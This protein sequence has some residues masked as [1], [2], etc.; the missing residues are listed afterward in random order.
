MP[1]RSTAE[2]PTST[3][4]TAT[5][6]NSNNLVEVLASTVGPGYAASPTLEGSP[7]RQGVTEGV[8]AL[9]A[10][11]TA[12]ANDKSNKSKTEK[13]AAHKPRD[14]VNACWTVDGKEF[15][16]WTPANAPRG[17]VDKITDWNRC[18]QIFPMFSDARIAAGG[19]MTADV[20]KCQLKPVNASDYKTAPTT[21]QM[22][23][24]RETF[25]G[26]VCD[27]SK[28]GVGQDAKLVS[29]AIFKD[30]GVWE[31]LQ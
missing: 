20:L 14:L 3:C 29:W 21:E 17:K 9:D 1:T 6:R 30:V 19:P 15:A 13:V 7:F 24:L 25:P 23:Q 4:T 10:W 12:I 22:A 18:N 11:M 5:T 16:D 8:A 27:W 26:G 2:T 31:A 28:P